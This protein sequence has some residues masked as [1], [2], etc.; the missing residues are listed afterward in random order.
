MKTK[1]FIFL[2]FIS[3]CLISC[4]NKPNGRYEFIASDGEVRFIDIISDTTAILGITGKESLVCKYR[5]E[6]NYIFFKNKLSDEGIFEIVKEGLKN[7]SGDLYLKKSDSNVVTNASKKDSVVSDGDTLVMEPIDSVTNTETKFDGKYRI[8]Y[9]NR[10]GST[11]YND[12]KGYGTLFCNTDSKGISFNLSMNFIER[13]GKIATYKISLSG[14]GDFNPSK[15][16]FKTPSGKKIERKVCIFAMNP[17]DNVSISYYVNLSTSNENIQSQDNTDPTQL[18]E[19]LK[20]NMIE[21]I[22]IEDTDTKKWAV[23]GVSN[24]NYFIEYFSAVQA[25]SLNQQEKI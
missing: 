18:L 14:L 7:P 8:E 11:S 5:I 3:L 24:P 1:Q 17:D 10:D 23:Q 4:S 6:K 19:F 13:E 21:K 20:T 22:M 2:F 12:S 25:F 9:N 16:T 15:I